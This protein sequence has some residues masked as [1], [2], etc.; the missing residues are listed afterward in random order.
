M[1]FQFLPA[2]PK[3]YDWFVKGAQNAVDAAQL[4][5]KMLE[6]PHDW[7]GRVDQ[8]S[9]LEHQGDFVTHEIF[10][11]LHKTFVTPLDPSDIEALA[12]SLDDVVDFIHAA[13]D[14]LML[15]HVERPSTYAQELAAIILAGTQ[16]IA[17]AVAILR[18][19]KRLP[20]ILP[21]VHEI[22]RL[23]N[24]ADRI[25]RAAISQ[26]VEQREDIFEL[27][28]WKEIYGQLEGATDRCEDVADVL[29]T[30]VIKYA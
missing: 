14:S 9:E 19:K 2:E 12:R 22:N 11:L 10:D 7:P 13:S 29:R 6:D 25:M 18:E 20:E 30:V 26:L 4:L 28:R 23:E 16:E 8:I 24:D 21:R 27:I 1:P 17:A 3:F 15:Y 5:V